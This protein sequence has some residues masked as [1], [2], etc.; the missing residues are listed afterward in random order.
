[1]EFVLNTIFWT[2]AFY[3]LYEL[4]K[5]ILYISEYT[6]FKAKGI[7]LIIAVKN[8]EDKIEGFLRSS[9]FKILYG[10]EEYI[11]NIIVADLKSDDKTKEIAK[12]MS[13]DYEQLKVISWKECK[14]IIDN[15]DQ[16]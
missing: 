5:N 10:K 13:E 16:P 12:K 3:G 7:Y 11:K 14:D 8:Q 1:M 4:I 6:K 2:L 9:L 15:L